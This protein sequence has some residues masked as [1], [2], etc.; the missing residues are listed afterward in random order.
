[1]G[2]FTKPEPDMVGLVDLERREPWE[3]LMVRRQ[4]RFCLGRVE[5]EVRMVE[6]MAVLAEDMFVLFSRAHSQL[7]G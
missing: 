3:Q 2:T 5:L 4:I 7:M 1:M 6:K